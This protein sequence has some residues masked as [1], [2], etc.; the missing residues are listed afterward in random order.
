M[1]KVFLISVFSLMIAPVYFMFTGSIQDIYG[2]MAMPPRII[3]SI[4]TLDNYRHV[5]MWPL[6]IWIMNSIVAVVSVSIMSV[7]VCISSGYSFAFYRWKW[8]E[9]LWT[10]MLVGLMIPRISLIIPTFVIIRKLSLSG[11]LIAVILPIIYYPVGIYLSRIY[12]E[13][14][15]IS[16]LESA[17]L[18]GANELQILWKIVAPISKPVLTALALFSSINSLQD[19]IWQMLVLQK[20]SNQ[21][22]LAGMVKRAMTR[23]LGDLNI[24]PISRSLAVGVILLIPLLLVFLLANKYFTQSLGGAIKE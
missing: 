17:R 6:S 4:V 18:D 13:S 7:L 1:K 24:N 19:Y 23:G 15:P 10:I 11:T 5:S 3:P 14:I 20:E 8:K 21:T 16:L 2:I 12:F 22:L 9:A